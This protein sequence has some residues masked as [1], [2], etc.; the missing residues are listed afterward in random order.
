[1]T[2]DVQLDARQPCPRNATSCGRRTECL[3]VT[4]AD[5]RI[6]RFP[7]QRVRRDDRE[8]A[9]PCLPKGRHPQCRRRRSP[10]LPLHDRRTK[11]E[12]SRPVCRNRIHQPASTRLAAFRSMRESTIADPWHSRL[13]DRTKSTTSRE[14]GW[15]HFRCA[16]GERQSTSS[17]PFAGTES[18]CKHT[19]CCLRTNA[20]AYDPRFVALEASGS[21]GGC[22]TKGFRP[23]RLT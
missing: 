1:L 22:F 3:L 18:A 20:G 8:L 6:A 4:A 7:H 14:G 10:S 23:R 5:R 19:R 16:M 2:S 17:G 15:R 13:P 12:H 9:R 21:D 11:L